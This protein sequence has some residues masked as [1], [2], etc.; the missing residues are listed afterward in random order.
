MAS[1]A[2]VA[3]LQKQINPE[4][5]RL[6]TTQVNFLL[7]V[8]FGAVRAVL[9]AMCRKRYVS[10]TDS[11][12]VAVPSGAHG[13]LPSFPVIT[14]DGV[15]GPRGICLE[16]QPSLPSIAFV[17]TSHTSQPS[18]KG[19]W[20]ILG[21]TWDLNERETPLKRLREAGFRCFGGTS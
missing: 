13:F 21:H 7:T 14:W 8:T 9:P 2:G 20:E 18:C 3:T 6:N 12:H 17:Q 19:G 10:H 5:Q 16:W 1:Q 4:I 11:F 15:Q